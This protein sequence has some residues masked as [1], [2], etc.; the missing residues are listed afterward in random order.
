MSDD[1]GEGLAL[2]TAEQQQSRL[3]GKYRGL[4]TDV[5]DPE[6]MG[7]IKAQVP[8]ALHNG[9]TTWAMPCVPFAGRDH[10]L[11]LLPEVGDGVWI[12]FEAGDPSRPIWS[13]CWWSRDEGLPAPART[14]IRVL[15]TTPGHKVVIDEDADEIVLTHPGGAEVKL[16]SSEISLII[17]GSEITMTGSDLTLK[18]GSGQVKLSASGVSVNDGALEVS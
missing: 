17:G 18:S 5:D 16:T 6:S 10:G 11:A 4:A 8:E 13:G 1:Y 12:E 9:E 2:H 15:A 7:R 3:Y 14:T